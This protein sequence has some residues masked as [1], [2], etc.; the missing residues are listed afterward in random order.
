MREGI[1][2]IVQRLRDLRVPEHVINNNVL[3]V[4]RWR[5]SHP[6]T[7]RRMRQSEEMLKDWSLED[8]HFAS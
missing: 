6:P 8:S 4:E 2:S 1:E 7:I 5:K 3:A